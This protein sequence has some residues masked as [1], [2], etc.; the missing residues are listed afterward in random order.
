MKLEMLLRLGVIAGFLVMTASVNAGEQG[1]GPS[2]ADEHRTNDGAWRI[3]ATDSGYDSP[4]CMPAGLRH[5]EFENRG[6]EI[7]ELMFYMEIGRAS[8]RERV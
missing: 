7:H 8:C 6:S 3:V 5:L 4:P 2:D 1:C